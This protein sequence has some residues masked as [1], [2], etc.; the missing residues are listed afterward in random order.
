MNWFETY[1]AKKPK[2]PAIER[3]Y[4]VFRVRNGQFVQ[5]NP[6]DKFI[7]A[8]TEKQALSKAYQLY[9][10]LNDLRELSD[11]EYVSIQLDVKKDKELADYRA[12]LEKKKDDDIKGMWWNKD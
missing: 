5:V 6:I 7:M 10:I 12:Y 2:T 3:P 4:N 1:S 9:P 11:N 8:F